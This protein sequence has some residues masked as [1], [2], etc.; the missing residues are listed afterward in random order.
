MAVRRTIIFESRHQKWN[1][2]DLEEEQFLNQRITIKIRFG[3]IHSFKPN[4]RNGRHCCSETKVTTQVHTATKKFS[5]FEAN[6]INQKDF[7]SVYVTNRCPNYLWPLTRSSIDQQ[8][9]RDF[10]IVFPLHFQG[11]RVLEEVFQRVHVQKF[12]LFQFVIM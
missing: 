12:F 9:E 1:R 7:F 10:A 11:T 8:T 3:D 2:A 4:H 6:L 5:L